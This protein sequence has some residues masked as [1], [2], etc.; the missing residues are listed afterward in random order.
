MSISI[1]DVLKLPCMRG[2]KV[3]G[4]QAGLDNIVSAVSVLEYTEPTA[5]QD[6]LL[7]ST[8]Y[9][10]SELI[11]TAFASVKDSVEDQCNVI[12]RMSA[13][14]GVGIMLYYVGMFLKHINKRLLETADE[15]GFV[16]ICMPENRY[17]LR[18]SE[19]ITEIQYA[20]F[21]DQ[22]RSTNFVPEV[23]DKLSS[24][25]PQQ[26][27]MD[28]LLRIISDRLQV[29][30]I[31]I[32]RAWRLLNYASWPAMLE[33]D[34]LTLLDV[35]LNTDDK[36]DTIVG[37]GG[38]KQYFRKGRIKD[39][40]ALY[41]NLI[42]MGTEEQISEEIIRQIE[43]AVS[44][45][46]KMWNERKDNLGVLDFIRAVIRDEPVKMRQ[47]A[48]NLNM[49]EIQ[50]RNMILLKPLTVEIA[51][52]QKIMK[53]LRESLS[54]YCQT[55]VMDIYDDFVV[56]F[57]DDGVSSQWVPTLL[58][59]K[60]QIRQK[61]IACHVLYSCDLESTSEVRSAYISMAE[62]LDV[63]VRLY[64]KAEILSA[65]EI[66][67]AGQCREI[68]DQGEA[69]VM[70]QMR[71]LRVLKCGDP[72]L[73]RDLGETLTTFYFDAHMNVG[74]T[75]KQMFLH[76]NTIKYRLKKIS[77]KLGCRVTDMPEMMDLYRAV[78]LKRLL[79]E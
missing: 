19:A 47:L 64:P 74:E 68:I 42:V 38:E 54:R 6:E 18:Y 65:Y 77:E 72:D 69:A 45:F 34:I 36:S 31:I 51:D 28:S 30:V 11:I 58:D 75:S 12:R 78:A 32:D 56:V 70:D 53:I 5:L 66:R 73:E 61:K 24:L 67:F 49:D 37:R 26:R 15:L 13:T 79:E 27:S 35:V 57:L 7:R 21:Q 60:E 40:S 14:G 63:A 48:R 46:L 71:I 1:R 9:T 2:A 41:Q 23:L 55:L 39:N 16:L 44:L 50:I 3:I 8:E 43:E 62:M 4:G 33:R 22:N 10:G 25:L 17:E 20:I 76:P 52:Y 29:T 59:I